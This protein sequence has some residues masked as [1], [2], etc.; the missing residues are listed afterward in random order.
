MTV[1]GDYRSERAAVNNA[2]FTEIGGSAWRA[3]T[4][5]G[6]FR[7]VVAAV[8]RTRAGWLAVGPQGADVTEDDGRTWT[9]IEGEGYHAFAFAPGR[10]TGWGV[11][12]KGR[13]GRLTW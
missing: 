2:A 1:G 3:V 6:G 12:E 7:S 10:R 9:A 11:G 8:P 4:G 13:I 5:L